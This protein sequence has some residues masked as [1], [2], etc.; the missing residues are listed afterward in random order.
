[1]KVPEL[2]TIS[3]STYKPLKAK[4]TGTTIAACIFKDGVILGADT[5]STEDTMVANKNCSKIH[6]MAKNIYCCGAGTA[7]DTEYVTRMVSSD[8]ELH[9]LEADVDTVPVVMAKTLIKRY[10]YQYQG[11]VGAHLILGGVD[12]SGP[13]LTSIAAHGS[14]DTVPYL[15]MGSGMLAAM[16]VFESRYKPDMNLEEAKKLV[17]DSIASGIF[18]DLGSGSNVDLCVITKGKVDYLRNYE[19]LNKRAQRNGNYKYPIGTTAVLKATRIPIEVVSEVVQR[20]EP[21][22]E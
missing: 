8:L 1:M 2:E 3:D 12:N 9:R 13:V 16:S 10:L 15:T 6:Y 17:R 4:K 14:T 21:M 7:A 5:R 19:I 18:N 11:H 22:E 20:E